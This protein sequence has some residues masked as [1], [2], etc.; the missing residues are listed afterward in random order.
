MEG[1]VLVGYH[2]QQG[3]VCGTK[4]I[5][6]VVRT[7]LNFHYLHINNNTSQQNSITTRVIS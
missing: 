1:V 4:F 2:Y 5:P 6:A 3:G 7:N